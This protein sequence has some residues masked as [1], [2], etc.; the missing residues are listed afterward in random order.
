MFFILSSRRRIVLLMLH[1]KLFLIL[2]NFIENSDQ[3]L[4]FFLSACDECFR[5]APLPASRSISARGKL[6]LTARKTSKIASK[7]FVRIRLYLDISLHKGICLINIVIIGFVWVQR[8]LIHGKSLISYQRVLLPVFYSRKRRWKSFPFTSLAHVKKGP[9]L[10]DSRRRVK[11]YN[12][13]E[14]LISIVR[15]R[16]GHKNFQPQTISDDD[17]DGHPRNNTSE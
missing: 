4:N 2:T 9:L 13:V 15:K 1:E 8:L 10:I 3:D 14:I 7:P 16:I 5:K 6:K 17:D 12:D 11:N